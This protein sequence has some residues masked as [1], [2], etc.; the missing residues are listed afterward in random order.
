MNRPSNISC[1]V[2]ACTGRGRE[3]RQQ[4]PVGDAR[5]GCWPG[6]PARSAG[7]ARSPLSTPHLNRRRITN[8]A[9]GRSG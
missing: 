4:R 3:D 1:L 9:G 7:S 2:S 5:R 6:S 8:R